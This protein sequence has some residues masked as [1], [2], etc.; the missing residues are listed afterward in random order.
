VIWRGIRGKCP[1]CGEAKIFEGYLNVA[2]KCEVCGAALGAMPADD[3]PVYVA[4]VVVVHLLALFIGL[5]F[6][7]HYMP[8][9]VGATVWLTLLVIA[10]CIVLRLAKG[11]VIGVLL[12]LGIYGRS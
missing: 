6:E 1:Q 8:G 4:M 11:A 9:T 5:I 10:C 2:P 7:I 3:T 12:K